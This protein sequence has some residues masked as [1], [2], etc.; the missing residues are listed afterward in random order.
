M[1]RYHASR[2]PCFSVADAKILCFNKTV[3]LTALVYAAP[4]TGKKLVFILYKVEIN[5]KTIFVLV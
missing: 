4:A 3:F 1:P 2:R 5:T